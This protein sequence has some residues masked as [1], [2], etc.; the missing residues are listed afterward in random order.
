MAALL[1]SIDAEADVAAR[2]IGVLK[3]E[4]EALNSGDLDSLD[5]LLQRKNDLAAELG[6]L[7]EQREAFL[8]SHGLGSD[9]AGME[10]W[11]VAHPARKVAQKA[12]SRLLLLA[13]EARE[14]NRLNGE[15]I[16]IRVQHNAQALEALLGASRPP[17]LYGPDGQSAPHSRRR[18]DDAA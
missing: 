4:R 9:R 11:L 14:I 6:R 16:Q 18:I 12:W 10:S 15:L 7:A 1:H 8:A 3:L 2:F 13:G 17:S 5:A